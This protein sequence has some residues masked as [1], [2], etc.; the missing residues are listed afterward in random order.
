MLTMI[1]QKAY[2]PFVLSD[3]FVELSLKAGA[4]RLSLVTTAS[5]ILDVSFP[6]KFSKLLDRNPLATKH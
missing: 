1:K 6:L 5:S 3:T 4:I 2:R